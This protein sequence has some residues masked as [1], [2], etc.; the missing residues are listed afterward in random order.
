MSASVMEKI[1]SCVASV[2][3]ASLPVGT[4]IDRDRTIPYAQDEHPAV[5]VKRLPTGSTRH[6]ENLIHT[7][8]EFEIDFHTVVAPVGTSADAL[9]MAAHAA[10]A[11]SSALN[12]LG[13]GLVCVSS[14]FASDEAE[15]SAGRITARYQIQF[16]TRPGD[17]T[18]AIT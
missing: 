8:A 9:H 3:S 4:S 2:L 11:A 16:L 18:R 5:N 15:F 12:S 10:L 13:R 7:L 17:L 1:L 6:A 14:D